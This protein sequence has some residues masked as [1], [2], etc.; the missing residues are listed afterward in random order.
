MSTTTPNT[1]SAIEHL[2]LTSDGQHGRTA[3]RQKVDEGDVKRSRDSPTRFQAGAETYGPTP[4]QNSPALRDVSSHALSVQF[5]AS[6]WGV[7][8]RLHLFPTPTPPRITY[9]LAHTSS[10]GCRC[11]RTS[12][13]S[14]VTASVARRYQRARTG[15]SDHPVCRADEPE[16]WL[17]GWRRVGMIVESL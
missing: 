16:Q 10:Y 17:A 9:M 1:P 2:R 8:F 14:H 15:Q 6:E 11:R 7:W 3:N 13:W 5:F 12:C 4:V